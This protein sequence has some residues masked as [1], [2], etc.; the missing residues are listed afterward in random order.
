M[1]SK[2][3]RKNKKFKF[4]DNNFDFSWDTSLDN[5]NKKPEPNYAKLLRDVYKY[6]PDKHEF[7]KDK[8]KISGK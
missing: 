5:P 7:D 3:N 4:E 6:D 2:K 8:F 1:L